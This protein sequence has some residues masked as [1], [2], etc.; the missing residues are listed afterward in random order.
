MP[1][2]RDIFFLLRHYITHSVILDCLS[3]PSSVA[4]YFLLFPPKLTLKTAQ[5]PPNSNKKQPK[6]RPKVKVMPTALVTV[7]M[8][9]YHLCL[10][11]RIGMIILTLWFGKTEWE[12]FHSGLVL[13]KSYSVLS[14]HKVKIL[15]PTL[16]T[17]HN[18]IRKPNR[19]QKTEVT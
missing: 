3:L 2:H 9:L 4:R 19:G 18:V 8:I 15:I 10:A 17:R 6:T 14:N 16:C 7:E 11:H 1:I 5:N 13:V 12:Q